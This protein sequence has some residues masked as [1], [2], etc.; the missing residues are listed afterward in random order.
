MTPADSLQPDGNQAAVRLTSRHFVRVQANH[1]DTT[2]A[3]KDAQVVRVDGDDV[4]LLFGYDRWNR[5]QGVR[6]VGLEMW[7]M[8]ELDLSTIN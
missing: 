4:L 2:R 6:C 8:N 7:S 1:P 5:D 3:G